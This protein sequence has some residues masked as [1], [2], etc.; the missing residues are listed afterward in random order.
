MIALLKTQGITMNVEELAKC[1]QK[2]NSLSEKERL[3]LIA[4]YADTPLWPWL[5]G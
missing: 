1:R 3:Q 5:A 4:Q 2:Y